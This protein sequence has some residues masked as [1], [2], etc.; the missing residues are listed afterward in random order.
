MSAKKFLSQLQRMN[1][2]NKIQQED[3]QVRKDNKIPSAHTISYSAQVDTQF[4]TSRTLINKV[5]ERNVNYTH[6]ELFV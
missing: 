6:C 2:R 3:T 4:N 5:V 1:Q